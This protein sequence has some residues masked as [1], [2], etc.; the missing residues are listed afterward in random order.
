M[1][2]AADLECGAARQVR[3]WACDAQRDKLC[4]MEVELRPHQPRT[5]HVAIRPAPVQREAGLGGGELIALMH[6]GRASIP[7][8]VV[9]QDSSALA[10]NGIRYFEWHLC[11]KLVANGGDSRLPR[12]QYRALTGR[13]PP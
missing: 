3:L 1:Q 12:P 11:A 5:V 9:V 2:I 10:L 4:A 6:L 7:P 8:S 13:I